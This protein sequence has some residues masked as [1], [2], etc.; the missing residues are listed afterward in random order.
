MDGIH[1]LGGKQGFGPVDVGEKEE[2]F[3]APW[4]ARLYGIV[5]AMRQP[6]EWN[7]DRFRHTR[8]CIDPVD[9]LTRPYFDQWLQTYGALMI[10]SGIA[11][12][13]ELAMGRSESGA[14]KLGPP[15][16]PEAVAS[17]SKASA[18]FDRADGGA[19]RFAI[20]DRV[21]TNSLGSTGHTRLPAYARG[22]IGEIIR[23]HG[24]HILPD[25]SARGIERAE[26]LYTV[27][28][29]AA[30]LWPEAASRRDHVFIDLW[31]SYLERA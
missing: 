20:G 25:L 27:A 2:P 12:A 6:P 28:F 8:E 23:H 15:M 19:P 26:A 13:K 1:D 7:I 10:G 24:A 21:R 3:H 14:A 22:R 31:D 18:R 4:E 11:T 16:A 9:Y 17:A 5:R 30:E 29:A